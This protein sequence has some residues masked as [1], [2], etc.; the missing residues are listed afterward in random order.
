MKIKDI[1]AYLFRSN[2]KN[3][4][5]SQYLTLHSRPALFV[6]VED[7][8]GNQGWGEVWC[9]FPQQG[10]EY[11]ARIISEHI[12]QIIKDIEFSHPAEVYKKLEMI[13]KLYA[14]QSG[15]F[16]AYAQVLSGV[17]CAV[18]DL[19][20]KIAGLPLAKF[21]NS[22]AELKV[23]CYASAIDVNNPGPEALKA[24]EAG[25][26]KV[27]LKVGFPGDKDLNNLEEINQYTDN[28][29]TILLDYNQKAN[30]ADEAKDV[31]TKIENYN[32]GF[33]EEPLIVTAPSKE[34]LKLAEMTDIPLASG[35]NIMGDEQFHRYITDKCISH[36][37]L[38]VAKWGGITKAIKN[39]ELANQQNIK[40]S[41]HS[42]SGGIALLASAH[43]LSA[44]GNSGFQELD[45]NDNPMRKFVESAY[46]IKDGKMLLNEAP[47]IGI[48]PDISLLKDYR[49]M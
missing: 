14:I 4:V 7:Y 39:A 46:Q 18:W 3:P 32:I 37:Q 23:N 49:I 20:S 40:I 48:C 42:L 44:S 34:W 12:S 27:K 9:N 10:P 16:G 29:L 2:L 33:L 17:D 35:E 36:L 25:F 15:D 47:G 31:V 30:T 24:M 22:E 21:I 38:D 13:L 1:Q 45:A 43:F 19:S 41:P 11:R 6:V 5:K 28:K 8:E 26:N